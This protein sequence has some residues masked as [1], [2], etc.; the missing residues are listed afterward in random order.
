MIPK[1][2]VLALLALAGCA[3]TT[4]AEKFLDKLEVTV[5]ADLDAAIAVAAAHND[6]MAVTCLTALKAYV[7]TAKPSAEQVKGAISA[8]ETA[9]ATRISLQ[10]GSASPLKIACAPLLMDE[11]EFM[12]RL[13]IMFGK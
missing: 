1:L 7:G 6:P 3:T 10:G 5:V 2:S 13:L 4:P 12:A 9:R 8:W 11:R